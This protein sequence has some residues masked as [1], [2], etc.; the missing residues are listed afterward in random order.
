[1]QIKSL[2]FL[3][4]AFLPFSS[5]ANENICLPKKKYG[6][7]IDICEYLKGV[8]NEMAN[9]LP[10]KVSKNMTIMN[11]VAVQNLLVLNAFVSYDRTHLINVAKSIN[12]DEEGLL[13]KHRN[14]T[15]NSVC[16]NKLYTSL[17]Y[18]G[19]EIDYQFKY[20]DGSMM[21]SIQIREDDC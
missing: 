19:A 5:F 3:L 10:M 17:L 13:E 2:V 15:L 4:C 6:Q 14:M 12:L 8:Q 20:N 16:T 9:S 1:M 7:D 11:A 18:F 21:T